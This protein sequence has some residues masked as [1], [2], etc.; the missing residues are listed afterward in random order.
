MR[1]CFDLDET[2]CT[3]RPYVDSVPIPETVAMISSLKEKGHD[4]I[5][6]TARGMSSCNGNI[7]AVLE[8]YEQLTLSQLESWGVKYDEIIFGKPSADLYVDDKGANV[9]II[10]YLDK[11]LR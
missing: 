6:H 8:K 10:P 5:I 2:I 3:G 1:I 7:D 9:L 4:I 11:I